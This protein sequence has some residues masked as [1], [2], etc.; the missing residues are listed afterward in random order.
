MGNLHVRKSNCKNNCMLLDKEY[1]NIRLLDKE[2]GETKALNPIA[3]A[4]FIRL[5]SR[6]VDSNFIINDFVKLYNMSPNTVC[7]YLN[8]LQMVGLLQKKMIRN[9]KGQFLQH[10]FLQECV[11]ETK[12]E[13]DY[14]DGYVLGE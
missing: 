3:E 5:L 1:L 6:K 9:K 4:F 13:K 11:N 7:K 2:T 8:E 10:Y 14:E 12:L